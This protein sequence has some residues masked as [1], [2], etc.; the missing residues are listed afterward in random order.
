M[1]PERAG[2]GKVFWKFY[3]DFHFIML[4]RS[5][6]G[7]WENLISERPL[8]K[9]R[10]ESEGEETLLEFFLAFHRLSGESVPLMRSFERSLGMTSL[11]ACGIVRGSLMSKTTPNT[12]VTG[13]AASKVFPFLWTL[14]RM[15]DEGS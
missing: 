4:F 8:V 7:V 2:V 13:E 14:S 1:F 10:E 6:F 15:V 3:F 9:D 5:S 12:L 11:G